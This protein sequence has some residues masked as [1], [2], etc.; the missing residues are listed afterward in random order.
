VVEPVPGHPLRYAIE[1]CSG[2]MF[3]ESLKSR[4]ATSGHDM[5]ETFAR[6]RYEKNAR[7]KSISGLFW[8]LRTILN[9]NKD[10]IKRCQRSRGAR[11]LSAEVETGSAKESARKH[12]TGVPRDT[13][14]P[15]K[16]LELKE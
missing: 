2:K 16:A 8:R 14:K 11:A 10:A 13:I 3:V 4:A 7:K 1:N 5:C 6:A 9:L 15:G 12:E